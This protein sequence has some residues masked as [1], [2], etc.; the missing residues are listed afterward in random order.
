MVISRIIA[1]KEAN[2]YST[3]GISVTEATA[4]EI[5]HDLV[6]GFI[7]VSAVYRFFYK[8]NLIVLKSCKMLSK[9][10]I[11]VLCFGRDL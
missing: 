2:S 3:M 10:S 7:E 5:N 6:C 4:A 1:S 8:P 9:S 11:M